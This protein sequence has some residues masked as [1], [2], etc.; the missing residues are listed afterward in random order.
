MP[1][2][3]DTSPPAGRTAGDQQTPRL[4][5][6]SVLR[7]AAGAGVAGIAVTAL[8]GTAVPAFAAATKTAGP[9]PRGAAAEPAGA[10]PAEQL[11]VHVRNA[12]SGE[13]DLF[14]G[15][16]HTRVQD[17]DLAARLIRA[18]R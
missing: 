5:R 8:G 13:I 2:H 4:S 10:D 7:S 16:G 11:V 1:G 6:R 18:S 14:R 17:P 15:T 3:D 9:A 12:R